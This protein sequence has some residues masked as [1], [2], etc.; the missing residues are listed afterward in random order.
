MGSHKTV[1]LTEV[2]MKSN[3]PPATGR[4]PACFPAA[5]EGNFILSIQYS[6]DTSHKRNPVSV[7]IILKLSGSESYPALEGGVGKKLISLSQQRK[8]RI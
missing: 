5:A 4:G 8:P 7:L 2:Q 1:N 3:L 6:Y